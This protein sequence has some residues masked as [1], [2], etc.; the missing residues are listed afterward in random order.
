MPYSLF[1]VGFDPTTLSPKPYIAPSNSLPTI[2][3]IK[4]VAQESNSTLGDI[5]VIVNIH[6]APKMHI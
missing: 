4:L 5:Y 1:L 6:T 2:T 3:F